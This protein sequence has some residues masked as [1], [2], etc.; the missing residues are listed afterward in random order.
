MITPI[1]TTVDGAELQPAVADERG[2]RQ[3]RSDPDG[4][5]EVDRD[6]KAA[7][8]GREPGRAPTRSARF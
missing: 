8:H 6:L 2:R 5:R 7:G 4:D 3:N 1:S